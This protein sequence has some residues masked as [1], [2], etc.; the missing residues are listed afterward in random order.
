MFAKYDVWGV[1]AGWNVT[2]GAF[3]ATPPHGAELP[4][5]YGVAGEADTVMLSPTLGAAFGSTV[6]DVVSTAVV[7]CTVRVTGWPVISDVPARVSPSVPLV[8]C[9]FVTVRVG[10]TRSTWLEM[11]SVIR[12]S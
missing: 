5:Q 8:C 4:W 7:A 1:I 2:V 6:P 11:G 3:A 10:A 12:R 9:T